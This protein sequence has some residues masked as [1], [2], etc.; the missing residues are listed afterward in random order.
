MTYPHMRNLPTLLTLLSLQRLD[1]RHEREICPVGERIGADPF[2][3]IYWRLFF[4]LRPSP[5]PRA[6]S[7]RCGR[8]VAPVFGFQG[9]TG[10]WIPLPPVQTRVGRVWGKRIER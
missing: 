1:S 3:K 6:R 4:S 8:D 10:A 7:P 9:G 5:R 2:T